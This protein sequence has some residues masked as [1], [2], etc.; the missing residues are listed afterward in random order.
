MKHESEYLFSLNIIMLGD[1]LQGN[2]LKQMK[3]NKLVDQEE[4]K[5][6]E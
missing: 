6:M 2:K 1:L 5:H 3:T 4:E